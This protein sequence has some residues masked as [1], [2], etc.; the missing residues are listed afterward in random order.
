MLTLARTRAD[1]A[2]LHNVEFLHADAELHPFDERCYD[3]VIGRFGTMFFDDPESAF[4][5]LLPALRPGG[6]LAI[7]CWQD[8]FHSEW[9]IVRAAQPL[10]TSASRL[11]VARHSRPT[12]VR[13][14]RTHPPDH[15]G[16]RIRRRRC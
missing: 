11:R 16:R 7:V 14:S 4:I 9:I 10:P 1:A 6:R 3:T 2:A 15:R 5:N 13:R 8:I 12:R